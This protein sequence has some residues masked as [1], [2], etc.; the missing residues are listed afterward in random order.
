MMDF[1]IAPGKYTVAVEITDSASGRALASS[2]AVEGYGSRP[3][4]SDLM[5]ASAMRVA[6]ESDSVPKPGEI[7]KGNTLFSPS[8][9][10]RLTP[11]EPEAYY[12]LEAY[13]EGAEESGTMAVEVTDGPAR[14]SSRR[15]IRRSRWRHRAGC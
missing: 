12:V 14:R 10:L 4:A 15:P 9:V 13:N 2:L 3:E 8:A 6:S 1:A 5:L 11:L 7:R